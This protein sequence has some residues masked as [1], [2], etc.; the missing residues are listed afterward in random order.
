MSTQIPLDQQHLAPNPLEQE[1]DGMS[2]MEHLVELRQRLVYIGLAIIIGM[3]FG[4]F[5]VLGPP[6]L[7]SYIVVTVTA[8]DGSNGPPTQGL[9][10]TE[11]FT[12]YM[13]VALTVGVILAM[14]VIVYQIIAF[15]SPG[16]LPNEKRY[17]FRA[18]P[19]VSLFFLA[20]VAFS[21]YIIAPTA[22]QFLLDFGDPDLIDQ[23]PAL[24]SLIET[25]TRLLLISGIVFEMPVV[26]Y[27]LAALGLVKAQTLASY[28]RYA[29]VAIIIIAA[30]ITP[31]GDPINLMLLAIPMYLLYEFGILLA[32]IAPKPKAA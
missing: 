5:L 1:E 26:I 27:I 31:T 19:F 24:S 3:G 22:V 28:R 25:V 21:W 11:V 4:V 29:M 9:T 15:I 8:R 17:L 20:G 2:L 18:L 14:P 12:S 13:V 7:V 23:R 10:S 30:I 16:L 6:Q 32:R